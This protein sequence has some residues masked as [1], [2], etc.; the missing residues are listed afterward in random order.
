MAEYTPVGQVV[1]LVITEDDT[2][3]YPDRVAVACQTCGALV[4]GTLTRAHD[5]SHGATS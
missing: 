4:A 1:P 2:P 5:L 3:A